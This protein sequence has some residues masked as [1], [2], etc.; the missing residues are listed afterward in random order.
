MIYRKRLIVDI[1]GLNYPNIGRNCFFCVFFY[2]NFAAEWRNK[3]FVIHT[4]RTSCNVMVVKLFHICHKIVV[5]QI[6]A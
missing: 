5:S 6:I 2:L 4:N 3:L 1:K